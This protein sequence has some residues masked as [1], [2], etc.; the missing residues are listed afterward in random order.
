MQEAIKKKMNE[1]DKEINIKFSSAKR[2]KKNLF[3][4][5]RALK[6]TDI[7]LLV[8]L[9]TEIQHWKEKYG[10]KSFLRNFKYIYVLYPVYKQNQMQCFLL[11]I[12]NWVALLKN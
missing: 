10:R 8:Q 2:V 11:E 4:W 12:R 7:F 9:F 6:R 3:S 1:I 5:A